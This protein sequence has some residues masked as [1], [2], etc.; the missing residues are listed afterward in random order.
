MDGI[1]S[2]TARAIRALD[3]LRLHP[4]ISAENLAERLGVTERAARRYVATLREAGI[5]IEGA[6]GPS[7]GYRL[8]RG[9][10]LAPVGFTEEEALGLVLQVLRG[11]PAAGRDDDLIGGALHKVVRA[12]PDAVGR[13]AALLREVAAATPDGYADQEPDPMVANELIEAIAANRGVVL[14]YRSEAGREMT[15]DVDPWSVVARTGRWYLLCYAHHA[16]AVRTY[17]VDRIRSVTRTTRRFD[18]PRDLDPVAALG[19]HLGVGWRY[20][21]RVTF[22]AP[23]DEVQK[24]IRPPMGRLEPHEAGCVLVGTTDDPVGYA[25]EWLSVVP[26]PFRVEGGDELRAAVADVG[27]QFTAAVTDQ[28]AAVIDPEE[29][30]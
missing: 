28:A 25:R 10:T 22:A 16:A 17:R 12:L 19:E 14:D 4:G 3:I 9:T 5:T 23:L 2:P 8:G 21:T 24:W 11:R 6:R 30:A 15:V 13:Q 1:A 27:R 7:G 20:A 26:F 18:L 29:D